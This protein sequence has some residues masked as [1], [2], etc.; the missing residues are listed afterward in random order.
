MHRSRQ[1]VFVSGAPGAGKT[2]LAVPLAA[3][4]GFALVCKEKIKE[5]LHDVLG[6]PR[7][8]L[9]WSRK[10][11][12]A[13]M[14]LLW[15]LAADAPSVVVEANFRPHDPYQ[16]KKLSTLAEHPVEVYCQCDPQL[17]ARRYIGRARTRHPVHAV[18][19]VPPNVSM[20]YDQPVGIGKLVTV[21]TAIPVDVM[22]VATVVRARLPRTIVS[23]R[24]GK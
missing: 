6:A 18:A 1:V 22:A 10:L 2:S 23:E 21:N 7:P 14:E 17:A 16:R 19:S 24:S 13:A 15:A 5:T 4:L 11:G 9:A 20:E 3:E 12:A 8:D